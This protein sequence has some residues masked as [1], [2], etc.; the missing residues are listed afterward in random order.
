MYSKAIIEGKVETQVIYNIIGITI[1]GRKEVLGFYLSESEGANF[2]L[3][4]LTDLQNRVIEDMLIV[5]VVHQ[6]RNLLKYVSYKNKKKFIEDL[7][8]VY[9]TDIKELAEINLLEL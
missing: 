5:Y 2:W 8:L 9:K 4:V 3:L 6:I 1:E 7:K